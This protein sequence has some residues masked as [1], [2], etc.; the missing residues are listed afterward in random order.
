MRSPRD[1]DTAVEEERLQARADRGSRR[2]AAGP[3]VKMKPRYSEVADQLLLNIITGKYPI[4]SSL[5]SEAE[6]CHEY[7]VSRHTVREAVRVLQTRGLV[8]R[9]QGRG[10]YVE[11]DR[12][13][14]R[15]GLLLSSI[16]E[17]ER[18]GRDTHLV[19]LHMKEVVADEALG[20]LLPCAI[21]DAMLYIESYREPRDPGLGLP[22]AWNE[23]Y[24]PMR[25]AGI[26]DEIE[27]WNGAVYS[28]IERRYGER[29]V[30]I[31]QEA[32]GLLLNSELARRLKVKR[33][34]PGLR[35]KRVYMREDRSP[36]ICGFNTYVADQFTLVMEMKSEHH[37]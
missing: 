29:V 14:P 37:D 20:A 4:G 7:G 27:R 25:Y 19:D 35:I 13:K 26:R 2:A 5:P 9:Q 1:L 28:L 12:I 23:T 36:L 10:T 21:G 3:A 22:V 33:G 16:D 6:L 24:I 15:F 8:S 31:R 32:S 30:A 11:T 17:V 34:T 18:H